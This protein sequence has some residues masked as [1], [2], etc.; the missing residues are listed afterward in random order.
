ME[1]RAVRDMLRRHPAARMSCE[2]FLG[3][4]D[5]VRGDASVPRLMDVRQPWGLA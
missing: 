5:G 1:A 4:E 3:L 2:D